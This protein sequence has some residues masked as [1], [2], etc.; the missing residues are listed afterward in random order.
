MKTDINRWG[1]WRLHDHETLGPV[2][3]REWDDP[4]RHYWI[5]LR[6][7]TSSAEVLD[8]VMHTSRHSWVDEVALSGLVRALDDVLDPMANLCSF[9]R[10]T[11]LRR[12]RLREILARAL[13]QD[14]RA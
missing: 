6:R 10:P 13:A 1:P 5:E 2:L 11:T 14:A 12:K 9:G 7:C 8:I 4:S 3:E